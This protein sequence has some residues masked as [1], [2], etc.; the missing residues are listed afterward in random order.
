[1][2]KKISFLSHYT[3]VSGAADRFEEYLIGNGY[4]VDKIAF[5]LE[6]GS[7]LPTLITKN[8]KVVKSKHRV[9]LGVFNWLLDVIYGLRFLNNNR[10]SNVT[11][12]VNTLDAFTI[13]LYKKFFNRKPKAIYYASDFSKIR[14]ENIKLNS[15]YFA[16]EKYV[17]NNMDLVI[18]NTIRAESIR[19]DM[20]L[21]KSKSIVIPNGVL[22]PSPEFKRKELNTSNFVYIGNLNKEHGLIN[23]LTECPSIVKNLTVIGDGKDLGKLTKL[24]IKEKINLIY[25]GSMPHDEVLDFLKSF[26]GFGLAPYVNESHIYFGSSLKVNEYISCNVPVLMSDV[27]DIA[28]VVLNNGLGIV[29]KNLSCVEIRALIGAFSNK[30][31]HLK[32]RAFYEDYNSDKLFSKIPL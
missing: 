3:L 22:L 5:N 30:G 24:C 10:D 29:Y 1:M 26:S 12:G 14:F 4:M 19:L 2:S 25:K 7:N 18:S 9:N 6:L 23:F 28:E 21:S 15:M 31:F 17:L 27:V 8:G 11:I 13:V 20:G 16:I 32:A